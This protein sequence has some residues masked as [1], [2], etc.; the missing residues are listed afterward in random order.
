[1]IN[2]I[3]IKEADLHTLSRTQAEHAE[4][5]LAYDWGWTANLEF[6]AVKK[7]PQI[8]TRNPPDLLRGWLIPPHIARRW[9]YYAKAINKAGDLVLKLGR[10]KTP[11][12]DIRADRKAREAA[13][14]RLGKQ[15]AAAKRAKL[16][17]A[18]KARKL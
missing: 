2:S 13:R 14:I 6:A 11:P 18:A 1:M 8:L 16:Q 10:R 5:Y 9:D 15:L 12:F 3:I 7:I 4:Q 17:A